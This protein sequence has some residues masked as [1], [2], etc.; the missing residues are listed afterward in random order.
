MFEYKK[1]FTKANRKSNKSISY[2]HGFFFGQF[3]HIRQ[4][5]V[6]LW[7]GQFYMNTAFNYLLIM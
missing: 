7:D 1:G 2:R 5:D 4:A 3:P 6:I